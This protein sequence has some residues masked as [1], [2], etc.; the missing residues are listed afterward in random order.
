MS[1]RP[2]TYVRPEA[3]AEFERIG[4]AA[5]RRLLDGMRP[6]EQFGNFV[7]PGLGEPGNRFLASEAQAWLEERQ[8]EDVELWA[9]ASL[10]TLGQ[11][12]APGFWTR[13]KVIRIAILVLAIAVLIFAW[14][15][16]R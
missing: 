13:P 2:I 14:V 11:P 6:Q 12:K 3:R 8:E 15:A 7:I 16:T 1:E 9:K 4:P 5:L 10:L